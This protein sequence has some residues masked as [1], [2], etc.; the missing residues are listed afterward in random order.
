MLLCLQIMN[1]DNCLGYVHNRHGKDPTMYWEKK[2]DVLHDLAG[3]HMRQRDPA[4]RWPLA[5]LLAA[6]RELEQDAASSR[7]GA[8]AGGVGQGRAR[9]Q[10]AKAQWLEA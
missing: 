9:E 7:A 4:Q 2:I 5:K 3:R 1:V 6:V 10:L 8:G